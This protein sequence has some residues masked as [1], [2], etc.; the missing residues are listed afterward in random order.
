[1][2]S[3][4]SLALSSHVMIWRK[5]GKGFCIKK[6]GDEIG[7]CCSGDGVVTDLAT[8]GRVLQETESEASDHIARSSYSVT[9]Q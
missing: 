1:M 6:Q 5:N 3:R 2:S 7:V 4:K 9:S 8:S